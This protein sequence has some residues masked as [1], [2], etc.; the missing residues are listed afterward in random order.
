MKKFLHTLPVF[1]IA[2]ALFSPLSAQFTEEEWDFDE[3][4][5]EEKQGKISGGI[6]HAGFAYPFTD[7]QATWGQSGGTTTAEGDGIPGNWGIDLSII[8]RN[9]VA[10]LGFYRDFTQNYTGLLGSHEVHNTYREFGLGYNIYSNKGLIVYST[11]NAGYVRN[12]A[13]LFYN[14]TD[15]APGFGDIVDGTAAGTIMTRNNAYLGGE[16][17]FDYMF[18]YDE[19]SGA[20]ITLGIRAG[21]NHQISSGDWK[22]FN[23]VVQG[24]PDLDMSGAYIRAS[25]G[26]AGWHRQ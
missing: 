1:L 2:M 3:E 6:L 15:P 8:M 5:K 18:G 16:A 10:K 24:G 21:Y 20:G 17:G 19:S 4:V 7:D 26:F 12:N 25:I 13:S 23:T 22:S 11:F 14:L 9:F